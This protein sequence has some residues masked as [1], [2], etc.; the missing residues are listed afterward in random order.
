MTLD[1]PDVP[2]AA[3][4]ALGA[5]LVLLSAYPYLLEVVHRRTRPRLFSW[6]TWTLLG[7]IATV[8]AYAEGEYASATLTAPR[9]WRWAPSLSRGGGCGN[10]VFERLYAV[11]LSGVALD[12]LL[13]SRYDSP[14]VGL[15]AALTIDLLAAVPAVRHACRNPP[16]ETT[17]AYLLCTAAAACSLA[18]MTRLTLVGS[19]YPLYLLV[20]NGMIAV[21]TL[22]APRRS[23]HFAGGPRARLSRQSVRKHRVRSF[24]LQAPAPRGD[25][26]GSPRRRLPVTSGAGSVPGTGGPLRGA[27][28]PGLI[29]APGADGFHGDRRA[30]AVST[31]PPRK[32]EPLGPPVDGSDSDPLVPVGTSIR[33]AAGWSG[34]GHPHGSDG[35]PAHRSVRTDGPPA[36]A[37]WN[38]RTSARRRQVAWRR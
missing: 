24:G 20:I 27:L 18:A 8:A 14:F 1:G 7:A 16:E 30:T 35:W 37:R 11:C 5:L 3:L 15:S 38:R 31:R 10:R 34:R 12:L 36:P 6:V 17:L 28:T 25:A 9:R 2:R 22:R 21:L 4:M 13:W 32:G 29:G 19:L 33:S 26:H 23:A